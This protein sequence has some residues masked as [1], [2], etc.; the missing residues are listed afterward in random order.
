MNVKPLVGVVGKLSTVGRHC[1]HHRCHHRRG[2]RWSRWGRWRKRMLVVVVTWRGRRRRFTPPTS[3]CRAMARIGLVLI[4]HRPGRRQ[5]ANLLENVPFCKGFFRIDGSVPH[6]R[7]R[8]RQAV[9]HWRLLL[10]IVLLLLHHHPSSTT[11]TAIRQGNV[12]GNRRRRFRRPSHR[13]GHALVAS[14]GHT[15]HP[16]RRRRRWPGRRSNHLRR[17]G[18]RSG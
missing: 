14:G 13:R 7:R 15:G 3:M 18:K 1:P 10:L 8:W 2:R 5:L 16:I 6:R 9:H 4:E 17:R 11:A 12:Q